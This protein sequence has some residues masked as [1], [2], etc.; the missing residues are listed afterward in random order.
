MALNP[1]IQHWIGTEEVASVMC[2]HVM[3]TPSLY[4]EKQS[5]FLPGIDSPNDYRWQDCIHFIVSQ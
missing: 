2:I 5:C 3:Y 4:R 1:D